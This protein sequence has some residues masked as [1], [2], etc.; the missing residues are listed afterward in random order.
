MTPS[1][2]GMTL[3]TPHVRSSDVMVMGDPLKYLLRRRLA[4]VAPF[5]SAQAANRGN[6]FHAMCAY[7]GDTHD[8][9]GARETEL[10]ALADHLG[11]GDDARK[12][13]LAR[14]KEDYDLAVSWYAAAQQVEFTHTGRRFTGNFLQ[15]LDQFETIGTEV[16]ITRPGSPPDTAQIDRLVLD[17]ENLWVVDYK[18]SKRSPTDLIVDGRRTVGRLTTC[19]IEFQTLHYCELAAWALQEGLLNVPTRTRLAG[20]M[21]VALQMPSIRLA[22]EDRDYKEYEH[23]LKS[24]PRKG[25][26][27]IRRDYTGDPKWENYTK[28]CADWLLATGPYT[29]LTAERAAAPPVNVSETPAELVFDSYHQGIY[30]TTHDAIVTHALCDD[31]P[32]RFPPNHG[33]LMYGSPY[34]PFYL[35]DVSYWPSIVE[36]DGFRVM[37]RDD[38]IEEGVMMFKKAAHV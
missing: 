25:Q 20:M 3:F 4:L 36:S 13:I 12:T 5:D 14:E 1:Q 22:R 31:D 34:E 11:C 8:L 18:T 16:F 30:N 35:L 37:S 32:R 23:T 38:G 26:T 15:F 33:S 10:M 24:G 27:E 28:R 19:S 29:H 2:L 21:H 7:D 9:L 17:G 6:W